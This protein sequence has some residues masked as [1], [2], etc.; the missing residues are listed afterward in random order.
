MNKIN[1]DTE[2]THTDQSLIDKNAIL[3]LQKIFISKRLVDTLQYSDKYPNH[4][5][6]IVHVN[7]AGEEN[8][9]KIWAQVKGSKSLD[10][11]KSYTFKQD[12]RHND[13]YPFLNYCRNHGKNDI[14]LLIWV[15]TRNEIGYWKHINQNE[16][17][18][19]L[20][21]KK[22]TKSIKFDKKN[23]ISKSSDQFITDWLDL[24]NNF[25]KN[26]IN[27][28]TPSFGQ[29]INTFIINLNYYINNEFPVITN[30]LFQKDKQLLGV[31]YKIYNNNDVSFSLNPININ[32]NQPLF[33]RQDYNIIDE[34]KQRLNI[35]HFN[36]NPIDLSPKRYAIETIHGLL[37]DIVR[38]D[39]FNFACSALLLEE[40]IFDLIR[41][42]EKLFNLER[43]T[44]YSVQEF[45]ELFYKSI[46]WIEKSSFFIINSE[47][48]RYAEYTSLANILIWDYS[49]IPYLNY[50]HIANLIDKK[51][52][53]E[54]WN[55][56]N[57]NYVT[58]KKDSE[59]LIELFKN[60]LYEKNR[61]LH[62]VDDYI[63]YYKSSN[64]NEFNSPYED[65]YLIDFSE[66]LDENKME[67][68]VCNN[69]EKMYNSFE[70]SYCNFMLTNFSENTSKLNIFYEN[71]TLLIL[72]TAGFEK[73]RND[74]WFGFMLL[75]NSSIS[76]QSKYLQ[77]EAA[78]KI[79]ENYNSIDKLVVIGEQKIKVIEFI[80]VGNDF[81]TLETHN[82]LKNLYL[83]NLINFWLKET[84]DP[85]FNYLIEN[86]KPYPNTFKKGNATASLSLT[87]KPSNPIAVKIQEIFELKGF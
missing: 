27:V 86:T 46:I 11:N 8:T 50:R 49:R 32:S 21:Q 44:K 20:K 82:D 39:L 85:Y 71:K 42:L 29:N 83:H 36:D 55:K 51:K 75:E 81:M 62:K 40:F 43:K 41:E 2:G 17:E 53:T 59:E 56:I 5:G 7:D 76:F 60:L 22:Q 77:G 1:K 30:S 37:N 3:T 13:R 34:D 16:A 61:R 67:L 72:N 84:I 66:S 73:E 48:A 74:S 52:Q 9:I 12:K 33:K 6:Y 23:I 10:I 18:N 64:L 26:I 28:E 25:K 65:L 80:L 57:D 68:I 78:I 70:N 38:K 63:E 58:Y 69:L 47:D 45:E 31:E 24:I 19:I 35:A 15:D 54:I 4:D 87:K 79:K 14:I